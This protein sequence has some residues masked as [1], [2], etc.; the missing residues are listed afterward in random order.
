MNS[1]IVVLQGQKGS[2]KTKGAFSLAHT[3][4]LSA[5]IKTERCAEIRNP[6]EVKWVCPNDLDLLTIDGIGNNPKMTP[7]WE[8]SLRYLESH[9][10]NS[11]MKIIITTRDPINLEFTTAK[12]RFKLTSKTVKLPDLGT[13]PG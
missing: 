10:G 8:E 12:G 1:N 9:I 5:V 6:S 7:V 4:T 3:L 11:S 13:W 2:G